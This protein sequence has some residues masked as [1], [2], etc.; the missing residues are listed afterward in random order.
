[1]MSP[2][3][4]SLQATMQVN[5]LT[6]KTGEQSFDLS[7]MVKPGKS[8][9]P[10]PAISSQLQNTRNWYWPEQPRDLQST[11]LRLIPIPSSMKTDLRFIRTG[12]VDGF[13]K[14]SWTQKEP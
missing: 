8:K 13:Q 4:R 10:R 14:R 11:M 5:G 6:I 2:A 3:E 1:M 9:T 12:P 7:T